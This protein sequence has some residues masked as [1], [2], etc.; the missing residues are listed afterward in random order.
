[1]PPTT[2]PSRWQWTDLESRE[3]NRECSRGCSDLSGCSSKHPGWTLVTSSIGSTCSGAASWLNW[4]D[5]L[6]SFRTLEDWLSRQILSWT[7]LWCQIFLEWM[8]DFVNIW[9]PEMRLLHL[10]HQRQ[11]RRRMLLFQVRVTRPDN[12]PQ[13]KNLKFILCWFRSKAQL[14][15]IFL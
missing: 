11:R 9:F 5:H 2:R 6:S 14:F 12:R 7:L 1:M 3:Q 15:E 4:Q 13:G 8:P 10:Q